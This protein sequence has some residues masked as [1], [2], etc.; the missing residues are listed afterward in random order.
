MR[1]AGLWSAAW[2]A[3]PALPCQPALPCPHRAALL[4]DATRYRCARMTRVLAEER[5]YGYGC[6]IHLH[7]FTSVPHLCQE[8]VSCSINP[9]QSRSTARH[10]PSPLKRG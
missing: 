6:W 10:E 4:R 1:R 9:L 8:N 3:R 7:L 5:L 2:P